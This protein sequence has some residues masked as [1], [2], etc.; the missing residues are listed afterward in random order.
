M[1]EIAKDAPVAV[2]SKRE[3]A[4]FLTTLQTMLYGMLGV[5]RNKHDIGEDKPKLSPVAL[6]VMAVIF[7]ACFVG[8]LVTL[9]TRIAAG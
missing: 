7:M 3:T 6:I 1:S 9:A 8:G 5:A 4:G 2:V